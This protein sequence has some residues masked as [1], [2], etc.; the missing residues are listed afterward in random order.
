MNKSA[1]ER[2]LSN[3]YPSS[4]SDRP[5]H[6]SHS[7]ENWTGD[8][9]F[10]GWLAH[11]SEIIDSKCCLIEDPR[12][13]VATVF[14]VD[15]QNITDLPLLSLHLRHFLEPISQ[16]ILHSGDHPPWAE[17][18]PSIAAFAARLKSCPITNPFLRPILVSPLWKM[19][20]LEHRYNAK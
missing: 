19:R 11:C 15:A 20:I 10:D 13:C 8:D 14:K 17:A 16:I 9:F 18:H 5:V 4:L 7:K 2:F 1:I 3:D 12:V 6:Y